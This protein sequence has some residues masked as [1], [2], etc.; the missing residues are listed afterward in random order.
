MVHTKYNASVEFSTHGSDFVE[1]N[2]RCVCG[3]VLSEEQIVSR[4]YSCD[5]QL[6][7]VELLC[8]DFENCETTIT[9]WLPEPFFRRKGVQL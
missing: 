5:S 1:N 7:A 8:S 9:V 3:K 2:C 6:I 4:K